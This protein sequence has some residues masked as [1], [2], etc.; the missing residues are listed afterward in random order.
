MNPAHI[1]MPYFL[2]RSWD[3][4]YHCVFHLCIVLPRG[5]PFRS[6]NQN[7]VL[8]VSSV[9][10]WWYAVRGRN[11]GAP[12]YAV[13]LASVM[14]QLLGP[15]IPLSN[16]LSL[17]ILVSIWYGPKL[18]LIGIRHIVMNMKHVNWLPWCLLCK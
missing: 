4:F 2:K 12:R 14:F 5:F 6:S 15:N 8:R 16:T 7:F 17:C 13:S 10:S 3:P 9:P 1:L 18:N 11:C